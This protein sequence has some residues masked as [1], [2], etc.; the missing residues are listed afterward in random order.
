[1]NILRPKN[2]VLTLVSLLLAPVAGYGQNMFVSFEALPERVRS[3]ITE[4]AGAVGFSAA[5]SGLGTG[6]TITINYGSA[7]T[8]ADPTTDIIFGSIGA[9]DTFRD[10]IL[11]GTPPDF[12]A[13]ANGVIRL[14]LDGNAITAGA[15]VRVDSV[16]L[17][18]SNRSGPVR[19]FV[20]T[21]GILLLNSNQFVLI[22]Q[23]SP[24][25]TADGGLPGAIVA[26]G[27]V[28]SPAASST[29]EVNETFD[30]AWQGNMTLEVRIPNLPP[31]IRVRLTNDPVITS[32]SIGLVFP[33]V[34]PAA[35][36]GPPTEAVFTSTTPVRENH[37]FLHRRQRRGRCWFL[38]THRCDFGAPWRVYSR[39]ALDAGHDGTAHRQCAAALRRGI[40]ASKWL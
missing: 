31:G 30:S 11:G 28:A 12:S 35:A 21:P 6:Q 7:I 29:F 17:D 36:G 18:V 22:N 23:L 37:R 39:F 13:A 24:G 38:C 32:S 16:F 4:S 27:P 26:D 10:A 5:D 8:N 34:A 25:M 15:G 19:G 3:G 14:T 2:L 20:G 33:D 40:T 1:M 9:D